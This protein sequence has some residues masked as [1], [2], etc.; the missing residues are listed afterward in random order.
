[1]TAAIQTISLEGL[2]RA[3]WLKLRRRGIGGSDVAAIIG[4]SK[5]RT[6]LDIYN[7]KTEE[8]EPADDQEEDNPSMEWGRRLEPVIR[9]KYADATGFRVS[10]PE[11]M[12]INTA[13][14]FMIADVD[15]ICEDG[16]ILECKTA[17][18]G[19]DW[20]EEG[21]DEI[22]QYYQTQVQHYMAVTGAQACDVAVLIGG[23]DFRIYT[24][25][26]D[27]ELIDL[28]IKEES[29]FWNQHVVPH[30]PPAPVSLSEIAAAFPT[31]D[32]KEKEASDQIADALNEM[33]VT[34]REIADK[35]A[36]L[37]ELKAEVQGYM[38]SSEKL[39]VNGVPAATW[40]SSKPRVTFDSKAFG[41]AEPELYKQYLKEGAP[42]RRFTIK[43]SFAES[44]A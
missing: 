4:I 36:H 27:Q 41:A 25:E 24:V 26:R 10:K 38:E 42:V 15:G 1:M 2:T 18:S 32:G 8:G 14:P 23:G 30:I 33:V 5:W 12:F 43:S 11:A 35:K 19:K 13:H 3:D 29:A 6:P 39:L 17:R 21:T 37:D 9:E 34:E 28:L 22:P 44:V 16:R 31:S 7:D 20:G 40:K